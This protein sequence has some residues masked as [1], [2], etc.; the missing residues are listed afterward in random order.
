MMFKENQDK[1]SME[2]A[3]NDD[4]SEMEKAMQTVIEA[5]KELKGI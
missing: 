3:E 1:N 5:A 4:V 2:L